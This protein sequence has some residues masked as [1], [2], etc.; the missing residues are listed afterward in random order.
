M[1]EELRIENVDELDEWPCQQLCG[2][3][4]AG[5]YDN[6]DGMCRHPECHPRNKD[7][8]S[9]IETDPLK[10]QIGGDH[11]KRFKIQPVEFIT[12][13]KLGF[14]EGCIIKRICRQKPGDLDKIKH[15][16]ELIKKLKTEETS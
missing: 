12:R 5:I 6:I 15:E 13:N 11:Y 10:I 3:R 2:G 8:Y 9:R 14:L 4:E 1:I 16:I 7:S